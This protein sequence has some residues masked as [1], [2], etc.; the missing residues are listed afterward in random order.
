M[1]TLHVVATLVARPGKANEL[2]ELLEGLIAPTHREE[3]CISYR[4]HRSHDNDHEFV[5]IEEWT[6]AASLDAHLQ[7]PHLRAALPQMPELLDGDLR[8]QKLVAVR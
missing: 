3:G 4:L 7:S 2:K 8:L 5:F 1:P 6:D